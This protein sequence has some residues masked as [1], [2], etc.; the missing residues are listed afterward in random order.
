M[1]CLLIPMINWQR[2][3]RNLLDVAFQYN[4]DVVAGNYKT[5]NE[6]ISRSIKN[7]RSKK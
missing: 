3:I 4:A 6:K 2:V 1:L 7:I 5:V